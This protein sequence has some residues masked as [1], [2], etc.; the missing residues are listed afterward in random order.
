MAQIPLHLPQQV[1]ATFNVRGD[2]PSPQSTGTM[3]ANLGVAGIGVITELHQRLAVD[4]QRRDFNESLL[5]AQKVLNDENE[6]ALLSNDPRGMLDGFNEKIE[7]RYSEIRDKIPNINDR[8][9]FDFQTLPG[10]TATRMNILKRQLKYE[11]DES[12]AQRTAQ[13]TELQRT[14]AVN[15]T[16]EMLLDVRDQV[17]AMT[18]EAVETGDMTPKEAQVWN[19]GAVG[20]LEKWLVTN[21]IHTGRYKEARARLKAGEFASIPPDQVNKLQKDILAEEQQKNYV[22]AHTVLIHGEAGDGFGAHLEGMRDEKE[23]SQGDFEKLWNMW[24]QNHKK[25][26]AEDA[27][28]AYVHISYHTGQAHLNPDDLDDRKKVTDYAMRNLDQ[29]FA[30][31]V[32]NLGIQAQEDAQRRGVESDFNPVEEIFNMR[33]NAIS[34]MNWTTPKHWL[35]DAFRV[36][37]NLEADPIG[38]ITAARFIVAAAQGSPEIMGRD[39]SGGTTSGVMRNGFDRAKEITRLANLQLS[40]SEIVKI[41]KDEEFRAEHTDEKDT[42]IEYK[43]FVDSNPDYIE[44]GLTEYFQA[45]ETRY[46]VLGDQTI[47]GWIVSNGPHDGESDQQ[48]AQSIMESVYNFTAGIIDEGFLDLEDIPLIGGGLDAAAGGIA[49]VVETASAFV[50]LGMVGDVQ[51]GEKARQREA[52]EVAAQESAPGLGRNQIGI[53]PDSISERV[54]TVFKDGVARITYPE[55]MKEDIAFLFEKRMMVNGGSKSEAMSWAVT[56]AIGAGWMPTKYHGPV[57]FEKNGV[58]VSEPIINGSHEWTRKALERDLNEKMGEFLAPYETMGGL[59]PQWRGLDHIDSYVADVFRVLTWRALDNPNHPFTDK[60]I[61]GKAAEIG[62]RWMNTIA[63]FGDVTEFPFNVYHDLATA[64][65]RGVEMLTEIDAGS[66]EVVLSDKT[67]AFKRHYYLSVRGRG[68]A[69]MPLWELPGF[70]T[71]RKEYYYDHTMAPEWKQEQRDIRQQKADIIVRRVARLAASQNLNEQQALKLA[72]QFLDTSGFPDAFI[73]Q[74]LAIHSG[75]ELKDLMSAPPGR[76]LSSAE[77]TAEGMHWTKL[78]HGNVPEY[79]READLEARK[80]EAQPPKNR[81]VLTDEEFAIKMK[82]KAIKDG[83]VSDGS[84]PNPPDGR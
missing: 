47:R 34:R 57:R 77:R 5:E 15:D 61:P 39:E 7:S 29:Q 9:R 37:A 21:L 84:T 13:L 10:L 75:A 63:S 3:A 6:K 22:D 24:N 76:A 68:G 14:L 50:T 72:R 55:A 62:R 4:R 49:D 46:R 26:M 71:H 69:Q 32:A 30:D 1:P 25:K 2:H 36:T 66:R 74:G 70:D 45:D 11:R 65:D 81:P 12:T 52:E 67:T 83:I 48:E 59:F 23:L 43:Q 20:A 51:F 16:P 78:M 82:M 27:S 54:K 58:E 31:D 19:H 28:D 17:D 42:R 35:A 44:R 18:T 41:I 33:H 80:R 79:D 73:T 64:G 53:K 56:H 38:A 40:P 60:T 8:K